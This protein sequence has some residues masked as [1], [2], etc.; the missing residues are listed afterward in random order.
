MDLFSWHVLFSHFRLRAV[1]LGNSFFQM[2][3]YSSAYE[4]ITSEKEKEKPVGNITWSEMGRK[5]VQ[6]KAV[7][8]VWVEASRK[9]HD[10]CH[11]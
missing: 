11:L 7:Q 1:A 8:Y 9:V 3:T 10:Q 2:S 6:A 5:N 4:C